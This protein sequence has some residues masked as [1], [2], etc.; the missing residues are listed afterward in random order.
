MMYFAFEPPMR[1]RE[2]A[3]LSARRYGKRRDDELKGAH[4]EEPSSCSLA[5]GTGRVLGVMRRSSV[6]VD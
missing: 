4:F 2:K 5:Q 6:Q 3:T 1:G